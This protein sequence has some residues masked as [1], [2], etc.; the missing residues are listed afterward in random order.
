MA[1][2]LLLP[3][4]A[5]LLLSSCFKNDYH[6]FAHEDASAFS[7]IASI[8]VGGEG[9]AEI[10]AYDPSTKKLF[11]VTNSGGATK[12]DVLDFSTP[13]LPSPIGFIDISSFGGG[14]NS[15][16]VND[17]HVAAAVEGFQKT[18]NGKVVVFKTSDYSVVK[19][20]T[21]GALPD[22]ITYSPDGKFILT[23]NEGEPNDLY[24]IDPLGTV[25]IISVKDDYAASTIDFSSFEPQLAFV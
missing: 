16:A 1:R 20:I 18:D 10:T 4:L 22:M 3:A 7:E 11:V 8:K 17:G 12:I 25:S 9:A 15:V 23:A 14:V 13:S 5:S 21:V 19:Q 2:K 24:T 6:E